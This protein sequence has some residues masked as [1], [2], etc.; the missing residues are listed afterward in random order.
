MFHRPVAY[1]GRGDI[2]ERLA[3]GIECTGAVRTAEPL[4][5]GNGVEIH[6]ERAHIDRDGSRRL[7]SIDQH[8]NAALAPHASHG[9]YIQRRARGP[10]HM[11]QRDQARARSNQLVDGLK[12]R[13]VS[14]GA[15]IGNANANAIAITDLIQWSEGADMFVIGGDNLIAGTP[16]KAIA[17][18]IHTLAG[19]IGQGNLALAGVQQARDAAAGSAIGGHNVIE[20]FCSQATI[21]PFLLHTLLHRLNHTGWQR[22]E[23][24][25]VEIDVRGGGRHFLTDTFDMCEVSQIATPLR[26]DENM[27]RLVEGNVS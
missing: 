16:V 12:Y 7:R 19:V 14:R 23:G 24:A 27:A 20:T 3:A 26:R 25:S 15:E 21:T 4:L 5:H 22:A 13:P 17:D 1:V 18:D 6:V 8:R 9:S 2:M 11:R 10:G